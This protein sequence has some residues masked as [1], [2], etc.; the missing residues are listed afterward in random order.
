MRIFDFDP[1]GLEEKLKSTKKRESVLSLGRL[2][3]FI[4]LLGFGVLSLSD[5]VIWLIPTLGFGILFIYLIQKFNHIQDQQKI[6]QALGLLADRK[7][8]RSQRKLKELDAG[9]EF[10]DKN[11]P[12]SGDL[13]LFGE[14]SL[15]QLVNHTFSPGGKSKLAQLMKEDLNP[16]ASKNRSFAVKTLSEKSDFLRAMEASGLA[17]SE[18]IP[19]NDTWKKWLGAEEKRSKINQIL[20]FLGPLGGLVLLGAT[21]W[22]NL[23]QGYLGLWVILGTISL[24]RV[25]G[26]LKQAADA[27]P[28]SS[29]L[30]SFGVRAHCI[31]QEVFRNS[32]LEEEKR[33]LF[34]GETSISQQL[35]QLDRLALWVQNR[36][37]LLYLP[38]NLLLWTDFLLY[39]RLQSWKSKAGPSLS[40]LPEHLADWEVW[41]SLG[42]FELEMEGKGKIAWSDDSFLDAEEISHPL[43]LPTKAVA[44]SLRFD[45]DQR[46]VIL[47]GANMSGKTTFMRTLGINWVLAKMGLSPFAES[48]SLGDFQLYTSMR[49]TDNLGESVSSFYAEL[50]RI[51]KLIDRLDSGE[52]VLFLLDEILKG[53]NTQDRISGSQALVDQILQTHGFGIISTHDIE[54]SELAKSKTGVKNYSFHSEIQDQEIKFDYLL[55]SGACPSFNAHKLME[56]M[57]IRFKPST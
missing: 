45:S 30:K 43:I 6:Y 55:K 46:L 16:D 52:K 39:D 20:S 9:L 40:S 15:F 56:L 14:H 24:S 36:M 2:I 25:F 12:F 50:F 57:G 10:T 34:G 5:S 13:D 22:G 47:T 18:D 38:I 41:V 19:L 54:L 8:Q 48:L 21:V 28:V 42:A 29:V 4:A 37:N 26:P 7:A 1:Q 3:V 17:F 32:L 44:N 49:N 23:P 27:L 35:N 53:T 31:E 11:H 51:K 33:K